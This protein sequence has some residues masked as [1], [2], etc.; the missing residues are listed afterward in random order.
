MERI[1]SI[2]SAR[3]FALFVLIIKLFQVPLLGV[4]KPTAFIFSIFPYICL[5]WTLAVVILDFSSKRNFLKNT[6]VLWILLFLISYVITSVMNFRYSFADNIELIFWMLMQYIIIYSCGREKDFEY[7]KKTLEIAAKFFVGIVFFMI[8]ISLALFILGVGGEV[9]IDEMPMRFGLRS[10][11]LFGVFASPNYSA[12]FSVISLVALAYFF[13]K[14]KSIA[15]KIIYIVMAVFIYLFLIL[16]VSN[17]GKISFVLAITMLSFGLFYSKIK[18]INF[19]K[20]ASS[21]IVAVIIS[22]ILVLPF[23]TIQTVSADIA[24]NI[25]SSSV[26]QPIKKGIEKGIVIMTGMHEKTDV[27]SNEEDGINFNELTEEDFNFERDD[28]AAEELS[29]GRRFTHDRYPIWEDAIKLL[30]PRNPVFGVSALGY[31]GRINDEYPESFISQYNKYSMHNDFVTLL[32]CCG[33]IGFVFMM[34]FIVIVV[35]K[36]IQYLI[37]YQSSIDML[38]RIWYPLIVIAILTVSMLY[39]DAVIVN[40]TIQSVVFWICMSYIMCVADENPK[41]N[42]FSKLFDK[43]FNLLN[44]KESN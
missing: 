25:H 29:F 4:F 6:G 23:G 20:M 28:F 41:D 15:K 42:I 24:K 40:M 19:W 21:I 39:S 17:T 30:L 10:R 14:A 36:V 37:K 8:V 22:V 9:I 43:I 27:D 13:A 26:V 1:K 34:I 33:I 16:T 5:L 38:K 35:K 3:N 11:R 7:N 44:R 2:L 12:L 31:M 18:K 32:T